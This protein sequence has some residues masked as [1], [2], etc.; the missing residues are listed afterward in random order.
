MCV[1][2][3]IVMSGQA[4]DFSV[5]LSSEAAGWSAWKGKERST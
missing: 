3:V 4:E 1:V 5:A 2:D